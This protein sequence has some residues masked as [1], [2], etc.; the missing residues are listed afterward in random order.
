[1]LHRKGLTKTDKNQKPTKNRNKAQGQGT[2]TRINNNII[3]TF[4]IFRIVRTTLD[5]IQSGYNVIFK[6]MT[7]G[8]VMTFRALIQSGRLNGAEFTC[9]TL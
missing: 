8:I 1:M 2:G 5:T 6:F 7:F 3:F 4:M 9:L